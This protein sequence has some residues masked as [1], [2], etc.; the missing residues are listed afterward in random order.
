MRIAASSEPFAT[1]AD[2]VEARGTSVVLGR[3]QNLCMHGSF[4]STP[5]GWVDA[6]IFIVARAALAGYGGEA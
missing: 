6:S 3:D 4:P 1:V 5:R 2:I